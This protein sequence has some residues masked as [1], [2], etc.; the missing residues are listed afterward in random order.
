MFLVAVGS[1]A[2]NGEEKA[3][4]CLFCTFDKTVV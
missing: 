3:A 4:F 2:N 1:L